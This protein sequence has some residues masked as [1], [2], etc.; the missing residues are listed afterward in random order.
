VLKPD[1]MYI[2]TYFSKAKYIIDESGRKGKKEQANYSLS[3]GQDFVNGFKENYIWQ[4]RPTIMQRV[5]KLN[6][7]LMFKT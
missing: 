4:R 7:I 5:H 6:F 2:L 1:G 3:S